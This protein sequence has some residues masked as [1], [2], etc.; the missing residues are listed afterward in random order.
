MQNYANGGYLMAQQHKRPCD[1][2]LDYGQYPTLAPLPRPVARCKNCRGSA[3]EF[4]LPD[5]IPVCKRCGQRLQLPV[6]METAQTAVKGPASAP[7]NIQLCASSIQTVLLRP[8]GTV[9]T[10]QSS[11]FS[12]Y[13]YGQSKVQDWSEIIAV[14]CYFSHTVGLRKDGT[15]LAAGINCA[16]QCNAQNWSGITAIAAGDLHIVG[17]Q[18]DGT[19]QGVGSNL[20]ERLNIRNWTNITAI[21]AG[22]GYTVGLR[23]D[24]TVLAIGRNTEGQCNVQDWS[25]IT[26]IAASGSRT[27]GLRKDGTVCVAGTK[28]GLSDLQNWSDITA[29]AVSSMHAVGLQKDRT[30][31]AVGANFNGQR[32]VQSWS[33]VIR[34]WA[35]DYFTAALTADG[36]ILCTDP[37]IQKWLREAMA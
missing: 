24:G 34:I 14:A 10:F 6:R 9:R 25:G 7:G 4:L 23:A 16:V 22:M 32:N 5:W 28:K 2:S 20:Y 33:N 15:V 27:V 1:P 3:F 8:D 31:V 37:E 36:T 19:V 17:L 26:A 12:K 13:D 11:S 35:A 29:I 30:V 21:A 18:K